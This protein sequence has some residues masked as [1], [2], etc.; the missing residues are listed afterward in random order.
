MRN[1]LLAAVFFCVS[2]GLFEKKKEVKFIKE[3]A[4][5]LQVGETFEYAYVPQESSSVVL[6]AS[7]IGTVTEITEE[8]VTLEIV[9]QV[10]TQFGTFPIKSKQIIPKEYVNLDTLVDLRET[11]ILQFPNAKLTWLGVT[12]EGCDLIKVTDIQGANNIELEAKFCAQFRN[13]PVLVAKAFGTIKITF[14][15]LAGQT[16]LSGQILV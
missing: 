15:L 4:R 1:I 16:G 9:G 6:D 13:V 3:Q 5:N 2:C 12:P 14:I 11:G 7:V 8:A 10:K